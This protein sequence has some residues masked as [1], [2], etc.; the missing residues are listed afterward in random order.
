[1]AL[2]Q[3]VVFCLQASD[4]EGNSKFLNLNIRVL[5]RFSPLTEEVHI[6]RHYRFTA[7]FCVTGWNYDNFMVPALP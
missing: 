5:T 2:N 6:Q 7:D 3:N 4:M 1:M